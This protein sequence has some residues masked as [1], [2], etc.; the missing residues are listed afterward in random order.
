MSSVYTLYESKN[1]VDKG[2]KDGTE[3]LQGRSSVFP[4]CRL[5]SLLVPYREWLSDQTYAANA[6]MSASVAVC[7]KPRDG[8]SFPVW[9][10]VS[11][12]P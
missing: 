6:W 5:S 4:S 12:T 2:L 3:G 8:I 1:R 9:D 11:G 7:S 10:S